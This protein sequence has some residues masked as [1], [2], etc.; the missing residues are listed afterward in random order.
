MRKKILD[1]SIEFHIRLL[2]FSFSC[3]SLSLSLS[4]SIFLS[5]SFSLSLSPSLSVPLSKGQWCKS[6]LKG[7]LNVRERAKKEVNARTKE[8]DKERYTERKIKRRVSLF[9]RQ[10]I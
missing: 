4:L 6:K 10:D 1:R 5:V 8:I 2:Q 9:P 7:V 3:F